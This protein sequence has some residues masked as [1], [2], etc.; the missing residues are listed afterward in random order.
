MIDVVECQPT[1]A[2]DIVNTDI[3][4]EMVNI[5]ADSEQS[6]KQIPNTNKMVEFEPKK[7]S[8][9]SK[10]NQNSNDPWAHL[11]LGRKLT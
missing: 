6:T 9:K 5:F 1:E 4:L 3:N 7:D 11:G 2:I 10:S 8:S